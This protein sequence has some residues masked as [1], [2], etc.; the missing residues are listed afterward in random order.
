MNWQS[1]SGMQ[2]VITTK[3][4]DDA[5]SLFIIKEGYNTRSIKTGVP[6]ICGSTIRLEH[7]STG[8]NLHS[9]NFPSFITNAQEICGF[10]VNGDGGNF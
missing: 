9:H 10:G 5:H 7:V 1:G 3:N 6:V 4:I 2:L 8:K